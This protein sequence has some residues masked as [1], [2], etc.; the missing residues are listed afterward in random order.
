MRTHYDNVLL[1]AIIWMTGAACDLYHN[2][3][4]TT[5]MYTLY[6]HDVLSR[7]QTEVHGRIAV[8]ESTTRT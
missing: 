4:Y 6:I 5:F 1:S 8:N 3:Q 2:I 7:A